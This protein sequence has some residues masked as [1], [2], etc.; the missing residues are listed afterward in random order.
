MARQRGYNWEISVTPTISTSAYTANDQVGG[1]I[2][3]TLSG[4]GAQDVTLQSLNILDKN[5][6]VL[7]PLEIIFFNQNPVATSVDNGAFS[8]PD[9]GLAYC[10]GVV[11]VAAAD[12]KAFALNS[13]ATVRNIGLKMRSDADGKIYVHVRTTGTPTYT[14]TSDLTLTFDFYGD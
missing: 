4:N 1:L 7:A 12:Y 14:S 6:G 3:L 13:V 9:S 11:S 8:I 10:M 2:T 5:A